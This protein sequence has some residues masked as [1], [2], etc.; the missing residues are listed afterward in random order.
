MGKLL[1]MA[2]VLAVRQALVAAV[3]LLAV[4]AEMAA[5]PK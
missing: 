2:A 3:V 4:A 1:R 5:T